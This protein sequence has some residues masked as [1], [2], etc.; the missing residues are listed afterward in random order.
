MLSEQLLLFKILSPRQ[1]LANLLNVKSV[2]SSNALRSLHS[3]INS[4]PETEPLRVYHAS[5]PDFIV[6]SVRCTRQ[7]LVIDISDQHRRLAGRCFDVMKTLRKNICD[8]DD[9]DQVQ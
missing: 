6:N 7:E 4:T 2:I 1:P 3:V 8:F 9:S 5:F